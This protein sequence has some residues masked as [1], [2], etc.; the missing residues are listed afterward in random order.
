MTWHPT[1]NRM[2]T[3]FLLAGM[4]ALI[5][6]VGSLFGRNVMFLALLM[7]L[8]MNAYV[9]FNSDKLALKSMHAQPITEVQAPQIY[10]MVRE[11]ST[12]AH[13]PMPRLY[14]SDTAKYGDL[15]RGPRVVDAR[16]RTE[17]KKILTE[18]QNG[19]FARQ[20]INEYK[21]GGKKYA[22]MMKADMAQPIEKVGAKLR[23]RMPWLSDQR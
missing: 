16:T 23:A 9:Y 10:A 12:A 11:L 21:S 2:K 15:T 14:I 6:F 18:I 3:F 4:S 5:V 13:Q 19:K 1:A 8:G 22:R 20:W 7:A 17:M